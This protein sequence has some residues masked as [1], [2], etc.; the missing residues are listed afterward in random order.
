VPAG[1][2]LVYAVFMEFLQY[3]LGPV[4][5]GLPPEAV[6]RKMAPIAIA[7]LVFLAVYMIVYA[8][9]LGATTVAVARIY[10]D[11]AVDVADTYRTVRPL[12]GRLVLLLVWSS[13]RVMLIC[14]GIFLIAAVIA[15]LTALF[16]PILGLVIV[17]AGTGVTILAAI[18]F[19]V[20][21]GVCVPAAVLEDLSPNRAIARSVQLTEDHRG[22]IFLILLCAIV[23]TYA[24]AAL[25]QGPFM[26]GAA[27][28]GPGTLTA[29]VLN[30]TGAVLGT[31]GTTFSAPIMI[32]G[33]ALA[34]YDLRIRKEALDL[35]MML[36]S[37]DAPRA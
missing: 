3:W 4:T 13:V 16:S 27:L 20:R 12:G 25:L 24:T 19:A 37:L 8:F 29:L 14:L 26:V 33:L 7:G 30:I 18:F 11:Q 23:I 5:P 28:A 36:Q 1:F 32:I 17:F 10:N 6:M 15:G 31:A 22:R 21:Y 35:Q 9:A 34:Y 2:T